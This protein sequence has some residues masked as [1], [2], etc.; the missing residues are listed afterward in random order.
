MKAYQVMDIEG[1]GMG[2]IVFHE[3]PGKAKA[4]ALSSVEWFEQ[5]EWL[6]L[7]V[8]REKRADKF[9][10]KDPSVLDFCSN[11]D[12]FHSIDWVCFS[13]GYCDSYSCPFKKDE[14]V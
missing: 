4:F 10:T 11:A 12:F 7:L 9:A 14:D 3:T 5:C 2:A 1:E 6:D 13:S 8:T